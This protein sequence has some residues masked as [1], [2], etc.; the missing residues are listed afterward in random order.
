MRVNLRQVVSLVLACVILWIT[1]LGVD[2]AIGQ[3]LTESVSC[4]AELEVDGESVDID[5]GHGVIWNA[6]FEVN[7]AIESVL[8]DYGCGNLPQ[9]LLCQRTVRGPPDRALFEV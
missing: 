6:D 7:G 5:D 9:S 2:R 1:M 8:N 3:N 4:V